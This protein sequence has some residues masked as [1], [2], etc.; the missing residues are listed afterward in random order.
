MTADEIKARID[1]LRD[2]RDALD[3]E[4]EQLTA[5][6]R[7]LT[8]D[9]HS[10]VLAFLEANPGASASTVRQRIESIDSETAGLC[11]HE[12]ALRAERDRVDDQRNRAE[13][14][15]IRPKHAAVVRA[16]AECLVRAGDLLEQESE[17]RLRANGL[18]DHRE[19][20]IP[21]CQPAGVGRAAL[22]FQ[23]HSS[24]GSLWIADLVRDKFLSGDESFLK[25]ANMRGFRTV[26]EARAASRV[27]AGKR[28]QMQ[29]AEW[30]AKERRAEAQ[31]AMFSN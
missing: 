22:D 1:D 5:D 12:R 27:S 3:T 16:L 30:Q 17:L 13:F 11:A 4:R 6:L 24:F 21:V 2:R 25:P 14:D 31:R 19:A 10:D 23:V 15:A 9:N 26:L 28:Q 18:V 7:T 8:S 20:S 29:L